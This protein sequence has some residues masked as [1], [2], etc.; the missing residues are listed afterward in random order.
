MTCTLGGK[1]MPATNVHTFFNSFDKKKGVVTFTRVARAKPFTLVNM[2]SGGDVKGRPNTN[3]YVKFT[4]TFSKTLKN[5][6]HG[7]C[8]FRRERHFYVNFT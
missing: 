3:F 5:F 2:T 7:I 6:T 4:T 8:T 1:N